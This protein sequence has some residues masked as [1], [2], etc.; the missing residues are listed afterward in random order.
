MT[1]ALPGRRELR[2]SLLIGLCCLLVYNANLRA[3]SAGDTYPARYL[4]FALWQ[5]HSLYLDA[6]APLANQ[7]RGPAAYWML[8]LPDGHI[9]SLYPVT[10]PVL[11]A[12][13]Y[14]PAVAYLH[15]RDWT[16]WRLDR[17]AK[18]GAAGPDPAP[19]RPPARRLRAG[20][21]RV[22]TGDAGT[23]PGGDVRNAIRTNAVAFGKRRAFAASLALFTLAQALLLLLALRG[24]LPRP[25]AAL[26][27]LYPLHLRWSWETLAE[28]LTYASISRLQA[29]YRALYAIV[30]LAMVAALYAHG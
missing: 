21:A 27:A 17:T 18:T 28:G 24:T 9:I 7:G 8:P 2:A 16:D 29:R 30:G 15:L 23:R 4:P 1:P 19:D 12:P 14:L 3:V 22:T 5:H 13:L 11:I 26:V 10:L 25:V 20:A 6:V